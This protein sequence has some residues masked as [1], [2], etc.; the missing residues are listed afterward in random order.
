MIDPSIHQSVT[1]IAF[2]E[3]MCAALARAFATA[4]HFAAPFIVDE[5]PNRFK[6]LSNNLH[7]LQHFSKYTPVY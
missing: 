5:F 7:S 2:D 4:Q 1:G 3:R 6:G